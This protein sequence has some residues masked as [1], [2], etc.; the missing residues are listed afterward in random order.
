[1]KALRGQKTQEISRQAHRFAALRHHKAG[2]ARLAHHRQPQGAGQEREEKTGRKRHRQH[3]QRSHELAG[4]AARITPLRQPGRGQGQGSEDEAV[5]DIVPVTQTDQ[6]QEET[7]LEQIGAAERAARRA[8]QSTH[9]VEHIKRNPLQRD[10][11][12]V[13]EQVR[14]VIGRKG[15]DQSRHK[16]RPEWPRPGDRKHS[17]TR[18]GCQSQ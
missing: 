17:P 7:R 3:A 9:D 6:K 1:M 8:L 16:S 5:E 10:Q 4:R 12:H 11:L 15:E 14:Q 13:A 2:N 18:E